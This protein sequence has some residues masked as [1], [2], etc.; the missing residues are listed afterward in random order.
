LINQLK[1]KYLKTFPNHFE[2][3]WTLWKP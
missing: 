1:K 3:L 2:H